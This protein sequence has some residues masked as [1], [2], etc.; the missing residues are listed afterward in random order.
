MN[1]VRRARGIRKIIR[2]YVF[3]KP[4]QK[5]VL[6]GSKVCRRSF[7]A[8]GARMS[9]SPSDSAILAWAGYETALEIMSGFWNRHPTFNMI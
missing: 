3:G 8:S 5:F 7:P 4:V 6:A 2:K 9:C 1:S